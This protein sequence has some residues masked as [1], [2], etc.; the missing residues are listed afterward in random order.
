MIAREFHNALEAKVQEIVDWQIESVMA[1]PG[2]ATRLART[3]ERQ[4]RKEARE[5]VMMVVERE[6]ATERRREIR[7]VMSKTPT[8]PRLPL[9]TAF[10]NTLNALL[11]KGSG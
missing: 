3:T 9:A 8:V 11:G 6:I 2:G 1:S 4:M 5:W 7:K 10:D